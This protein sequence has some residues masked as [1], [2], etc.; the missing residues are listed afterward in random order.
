VSQKIV[1]SAVD[2]VI[3]RDSGLVGVGSHHVEGEFSL[4]EKFGPA[5]D[6]KGRVGAGQDGGEMLF[7]GLYGSLSF[8]GAL[9]E[10]GN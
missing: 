10:G 1:W 5:V 4:W 3:C 8:V 9:V 6:G 2:A 7:E